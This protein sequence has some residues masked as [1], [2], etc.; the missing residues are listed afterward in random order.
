MRNGT[1]NGSVT[2]TAAQIRSRT[3]A[4]L[5]PTGARVER[6]SVR[7][8]THGSS[9][10]GAG[11]DVTGGPQ[12]GAGAVVDRGHRVVDVPGLVAGAADLT[13]TGELRQGVDVSHGGFQ[14]VRRGVWFDSRARWGVGQA[15]NERDGM[16]RLSCLRGRGARFTPR[17]MV[18]A[19]MRGTGGTVHSR[20]SSR[21]STLA[22]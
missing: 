8:A 17:T 6:V 16:A 10:E 1:T 19:A 21:S 11:S 15:T 9:V 22:T 20:G 4:P 7:L 14:S 3:L 12:V 13:L 5:A 18:G 2:A